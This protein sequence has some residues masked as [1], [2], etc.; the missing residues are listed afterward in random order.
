[1]RGPFRASAWI[2]FWRSVS[3]SFRA[4]DCNGGSIC[5]NRGYGYKNGLFWRVADVTA[6]VTGGVTTDC[7]VAA[8]HPG[9]SATGYWVTNNVFTY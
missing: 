8:L 2:D 9:G 4:R 1:M 6:Q 5:F 7:T 3:R